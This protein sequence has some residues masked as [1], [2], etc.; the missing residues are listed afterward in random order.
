MLPYLAVGPLHRR[1]GTGT[2]SVSTLLFSPPC[3]FHVCS[4]TACTQTT[5]HRHAVELTHEA[6]AA[7]LKALVALLERSAM[8]V[9]AEHFKWVLRA[10]FGNL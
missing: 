9:I 5:R 1:R 6:L 10:G 4:R 2:S 3:F 7:N 8:S